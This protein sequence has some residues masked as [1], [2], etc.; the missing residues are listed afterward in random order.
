M[1]KKG[2]TVYIVT[3]KER[4]KTGRV[5]RVLKSTK[6]VVVEG[7]NMYKKH[8]RPRKQGQKGEIISLS[9]SMHVSNVM[10]LCPK[11]GQRTRISHTI[12]N[13]TKT[14]ICK[15]CQSEF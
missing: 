2:D 8:S 7:V 15:K 4:G 6:R 10:H 5:T 14:R 13:G 9:R 12:S 11:C 1:I 3:G